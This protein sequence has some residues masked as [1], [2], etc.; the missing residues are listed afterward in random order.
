MS[1]VALYRKHRPD[2]FKKVE[3]QHVVI[4]TLQNALKKDRI[5]HAYLFAGPRGTGKTSVAKIFAR[6]INCENSING[7]CCNKCHS[8][9][10]LKEETIGDIIE[11]D[12]ASNNGVDEIRELREKARYATSFA[13]YKVY[14]I[15]EVHMLTT[16]AFNALLKTLE[17]PPQ[18]VVFI[19]ATTE[20]HKIPQTIISRCQCFEFKSIQASDINK[21][22]NEIVKQEDIKIDTEAIELIQKNSEG[23]LRN[24]I[25]LL[26][27]VIAYAPERITVD[28]V[29]VVSGSINKGRL[30][31][32]IKFINKRDLASSLILISKLITEGKEISK[33]TSD[34]ISLLKNVLVI[35]NTAS[36]DPSL[37]DL[38]KELSSS[39]LFYFITVLN[40]LLQDLRWTSQKQAYLEVAIIK[41]MDYLE[42][43]KVNYDDRINSLESKLNS[44]KEKININAF[45]NQNNESDVPVREDKTERDTLPNKRAERETY[46]NVREINKLLIS[47]DYKKRIKLESNLP[48]FLQKFEKS[49]I[50]N[51]L[52]GSKIVCVTGSEILFETTNT[53]QALIL[54]D[55]ENYKL[56]VSNLSYLD[57]TIIKPFFI[58]SEVWKKIKDA[59]YDQAKHNVAKPILPDI[60]LGLYKNKKRVNPAVDLA[61]KF[62]GEENVGTKE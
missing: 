20:V 37:A 41:M 27:Q 40:E 13:K 1:Y 62:F 22:L 42:G 54:W 9:K 31:E 14:I 15:D 3:G 21:K 46:T 2:S 23:A 39:K 38:D 32:L 30:I 17:E 35:K 18:N 25:S 55:E 16:Q 28:D 53:E 49:N 47:G 19:L 59:F 8:C 56:V 12:A 11:I 51:S 48:S 24:A 6:A 52:K 57:K 4:Q 60:N 61:V 36:K 29:Y 45:V 50:Y 7:D 10:A 44:L 26:D 5:G 33:L 43:D 58:G 34:L